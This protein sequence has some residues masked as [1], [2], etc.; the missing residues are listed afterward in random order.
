MQSVVLMGLIFMVS[1]ALKQEEDLD[2]SI[3]FADKKYA[4]CMHVVFLFIL[5]FP[6]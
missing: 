3:A 6:F 4:I 5:E 2:T 1:A